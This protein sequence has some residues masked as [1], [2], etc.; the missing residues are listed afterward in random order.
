MYQ[1]AAAITTSDT[2]KTDPLPR[3]IVATVGGTIKMTMLGGGVVTITAVAGVVYPV[4][5]VLIWATGTAATGIVA[6]Y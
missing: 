3:A 5:P 1:N 6:F 4:Q 2:V